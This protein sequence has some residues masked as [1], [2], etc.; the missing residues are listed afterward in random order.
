MKFGEI[1]ALQNSGNPLKIRRD[2][3]LP[4]GE[5]EVPRTIVLFS[6]SEDAS[7]GGSEISHATFR[8]CIEN[9]LEPKIV[10]KWPSFSPSFYVRPNCTCI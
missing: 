4:F 9:N 2:W 8:V 5:I 1:G 7:G 10:H 6:L 3:S